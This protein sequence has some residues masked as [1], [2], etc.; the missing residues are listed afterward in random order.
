VFVMMEKGNMIVDELVSKEDRVYTFRIGRT[1]ASAFAG[2]LA[3]F[4][5][6]M[7]AQWILGAGSQL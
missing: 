7:L 2:F 6:G 1:V 5:A 4:V 3:G